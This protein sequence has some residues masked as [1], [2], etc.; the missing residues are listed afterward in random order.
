MNEL[1]RDNNNDIP[2]NR[3]I[4]ARRRLVAELREPNVRR[5]GRDFPPPEF[6]I[7]REFGRIRLANESRI[8]S[9]DVKIYVCESLC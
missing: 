2:D 1:Y 7:E 4:S 9:A 8:G 3:F 6:F 5:T